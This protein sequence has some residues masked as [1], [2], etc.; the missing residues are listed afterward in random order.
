[1]ALTES[2]NESQW[3]TAHMSDN[4]ALVNKAKLVTE[5]LGGRMDYSG[6]INNMAGSIEKHLQHRGYEVQYR[7]KGEHE[8]ELILPDVNLVVTVSR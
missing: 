4:K 2:P 3:G 1:M 5:G 8:I 6:D 7:P